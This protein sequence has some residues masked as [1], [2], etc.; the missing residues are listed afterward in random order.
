MLG[1]VAPHDVGQHCVAVHWLLCC[2]S[3]HL[4]WHCTP[5]GAAR[6]GRACTYLRST[7]STRKGYMTDLRFQPNFT[8]VTTFTDNAHTVAD[9]AITCSW[10]SYIRSLVTPLY[11]VSTNSSM[12]ACMACGSYRDAKFVGCLHQWLSVCMCYSYHVAV[13]VHAVLC[14]TVWAWLVT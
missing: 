12:R 13:N 8:W 2:N 9:Y 4:T 3:C 5:A 10:W 6:L 11:A 7:D 1:S 14:I